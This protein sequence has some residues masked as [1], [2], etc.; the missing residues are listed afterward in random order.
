MPPERKD[1]PPGFVWGVA[2]AAHQIEGGNVNND[3]WA[4]E[5]TPGS[6]T[7]APSGDACDSFHRWREDID[8]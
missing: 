4:W 1:F 7:L 5:H 3:W 6:G 2:T 8:L